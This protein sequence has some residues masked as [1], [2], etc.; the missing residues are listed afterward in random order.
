MGPDGWLVGRAH[1][2][3]GYQ[4]GMSL[5][6]FAR[7]LRVN[8]R[9]PPL[10]SVTTNMKMTSHYFSRFMLFSLSPSAVHLSIK[11]VSFFFFSVFAVRVLVLHLGRLSD[12][13]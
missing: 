9:G 4:F 7:E 6:N 8:S 13:I 11:L 5:R 1:P 10:P 3:R 12:L 2:K